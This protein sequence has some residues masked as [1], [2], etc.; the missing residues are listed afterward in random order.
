MRRSAN[1]PRPYARRAMT[2]DFDLRKVT[3]PLLVHLI[4]KELR[5]PRLFLWRCALTVGRFKRRIDPSFP[6]ELV[7][8]AALPIW[9]YLHLKGRIGQPKAFEIMR[10]AILTG[11]VAKWNLQFQTVNVPRT[12][13]N[14]C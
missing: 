3:S 11:G 13:A 10:V 5:N 8:L 1:R 2:D 12:F 4:G 6:R 14:L 7:E 9:V